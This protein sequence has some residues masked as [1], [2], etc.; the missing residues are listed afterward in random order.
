MENLHVNAHVNGPAR[1]APRPVGAAVIARAVRAVRSL[2]F[3]VVYFA[4]LIFAV[5]LVQRLV[6]W[7]LALLLSGH[8]RSIVGWWLRLHAR[9][10]LA[11]A[12]WLANVRV[13]TRGAIAPGPCL[14]VMNHQS[15]FDIP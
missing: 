10:T 5:G 8:R 2:A 9:S 6:I 7:P 12:R 15:V 14:L 13:S 1:D 3:F 11:Q 4:Y